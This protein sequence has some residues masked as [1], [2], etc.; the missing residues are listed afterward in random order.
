MCLTTRTGAFCKTCIPPLLFKILTWLGYFNSAM[1]PV[2]YSIFN[3]EFRDAFKKILVSY[4]HNE[5][6]SDNYRRSSRGVHDPL[7]SS[8]PSYGGGGG[9][10]GN[11]STYQVG[12]QNTSLTVTSST[13]SG[14]RKTTIAAAATNATTTGR[15]IEEREVERAATSTTI[16]TTNVTSVKRMT[17]QDILD[18]DSRSLVSKNHSSDLNTSNSKICVSEN[19]KKLSLPDTRSLTSMQNTVSINSADSCVDKCTQEYEQNIQQQQQQYGGEEKSRVSLK[20]TNST[21]VETASCVSLLTK[22]DDAG[23]GDEEEEANFDETT[24]QL[25][26]SGKIDR[27][28]ELSFYSCPCSDHE[29]TS[30]TSSLAV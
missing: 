29:K 10:A 9:A 4:V 30:V 20:Q 1:N 24:S 25:I 5:C 22:D 12:Q 15:T 6:C 18:V 8:R 14:A 21:Q 26:P 7:V 23:G 17:P 13:P 11:N 27:N 16:T 19:G 28:I 3:T 2:I